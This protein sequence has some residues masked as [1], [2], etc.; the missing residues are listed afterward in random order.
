MAHLF[1]TVADDQLILVAA[2]AAY[3]TTG[4]HQVPRKVGRL[5]ID[6]IYSGSTTVLNRDTAGSTTDPPHVFHPSR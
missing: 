3:H 6:L 2:P 4:L 5:G 1:A